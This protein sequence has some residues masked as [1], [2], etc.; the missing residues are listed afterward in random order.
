MAAVT[1]STSDMNLKFKNILGALKLQLKGNATI[2][3]ISITGNNNEVLCGAAEVTAANGADPSINLTGTTKTV[4]LDCGA[5]GVTLDPSNAT[6]FIIALPPMTMEGGFTVVV[7]DKESHQMEIVTNK[8]QT[9]ARSRILKMPAMT[10]MDLSASG[11]A[12][13]Y[14]VSAAG[15]YKFN[16]TVKGNSAESVGTP[17]SAEVLW[18]SFG[19]STAPNVG[20]LVNTVSYSSDYVTFTATSAKGN[21]VIA[22]K[23]GS[24]NILWSWH[25]WCTDQPQEQAYNNGAGT[26]MDRN[27]GATSADPGKVEA[28]GLMYQ[29]GRKD[30][31]LSGKSI[32]SGDRA[33]STLSSSWPSAE[34]ASAHL[35]NG[36]TLS[37]SISHPTT[38]IRNISSPNDW[39]CTNSSNRNDNLWSSTKSMYDPCPKGW[40]VPDGGSSGVWSKA[41][42]TSASWTTA[43]NWNSTNN[44]M[45]FG[46]TNKST[47]KKLGTGTIWYPASGYLYTAGSPTNVGNTGLYWSS[48][49]SDGKACDFYFY[50]NGSVNPSSTSSYRANGMGVRCFKEPNM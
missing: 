35:S 33:A 10:V 7:T 39:Y 13:C 23:D 38:F 20:G 15:T 22:V 42:D 27:L 26:M 43:T 14:I 32:S 21:A 17:A 9:I 18:E 25:I 11:T 50:A 44:G 30:P 4:T 49:T 37:Y 46:S 28:L 5:E 29:W 40:R 12:N 48:S 8:S 1:S 19:T 34:D 47:D 45:N 16:A 36:N 2:A 6:A 3:S 31:F 24:G 41:F